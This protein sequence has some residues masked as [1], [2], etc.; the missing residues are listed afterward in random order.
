MFLPF[1]AAPIPFESGGDDDD[2]DDVNLFFSYPRE[3]ILAK[4]KVDPVG[5]VVPVDVPGLGNASCN[6]GECHDEAAGLRPPKP[7]M[8]L[9]NG[10][11]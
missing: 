9:D 5:G 8:L 3:A 2:D 1:K 6:D 7:P 4:E 10:G 11:D